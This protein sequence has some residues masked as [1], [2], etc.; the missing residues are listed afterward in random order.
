MY[1]LVRPLRRQGKPLDSD[2]AS[3][4]VARP[5]YLTIADED[6][7][8][9]R[10]ATRVARFRIGPEPRALE[11]MSPLFDV[12]IVGMGKNGFTIAGIE[13]QTAAEYAQSWLV[14]SLPEPLEDRME[15]LIPP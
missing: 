4:Y 6:D 12:V 7:P 1:F 2:A 10:R 5:G 14:V 9:N 11:T 8:E 3:S 13:R 15:R